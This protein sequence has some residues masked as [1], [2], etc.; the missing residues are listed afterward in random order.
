[1]CL[2]V[3]QS[4]RQH[5]HSIESIQLTSYSN[6]IQTI[7]LSYTVFEILSLIFHR[8]KRSRD[9]DHAHFRDGLSSV[10]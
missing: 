10:G 8:L 7:R 4:H 3:T 2:G 9:N 5:N 1:M 6:L